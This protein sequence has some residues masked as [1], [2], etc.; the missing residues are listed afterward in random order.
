MLK[1]TKCATKKGKWAMK[2][3]PCKHCH[4]KGLYGIY[5]KPKEKEKLGKLVQV[6]CKYCGK[7]S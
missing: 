4:K 6:K 7:H 3:V 2:Y 5:D 1:K